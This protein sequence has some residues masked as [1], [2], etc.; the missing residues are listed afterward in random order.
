M[1]R[2]RALGFAVRRRTPPNPW[3][4]CVI[5]R[6]G[7]IVGEGATHPPANWPDGLHAEAE[8]LA[9]AGD[10]AQGATVY[11]TLEPCSHHG[12]TPPCADA[13]IAA[14]VARV[15]VA[16]LD[17]DPLVSGAGLAR[18]R[19]AG[20]TV[21]VG[22]GATDAA[23]D[24]FSYLLHRRAGRAAVVVKVATTIDGRTAAADGTSQWITGPAARTDVHELRADSQ[25]VVIGAGT[26]LADQPTLTARD[27]EDTT[28]VQPQRVLLDARGRVPATG[29]LF[30]VTFAPTTV[31]T[32][33]AA[34]PDAVA[35]WRDSGAEVHCVAAAVGG[36]G[37]DLQAVFALLGK[38]GVLQALV[39]PG[40]TLAGALVEHGPLDR[41]ITYVAPALL[42]TRGRAAFDWAGPDTINDAL[43]WRIARVTHLD[44]DVRLD[45]VPTANPF[46]REV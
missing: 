4:G 29:P 10:R 9:A 17:P 36:I 2:A 31:V 26:A 28:V 37:V 12:R 23:D 16:V 35:A 40:P 8:A 22:V 43:R 11:T 7:E 19:D 38:Q 42:G 18:L 39:E 46:E 30:D 33:D 3:V 21:D 27:L 34:S 1:A 5:V 45:L 15:V 32:T 6:D 20:I 25:A 14:D 13:L 44:P 24:L 41:M